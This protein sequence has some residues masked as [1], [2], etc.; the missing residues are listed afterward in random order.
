MTE[1]DLTQEE[2]EAAEK[3]VRHEVGNAYDVI[4]LTKDYE[5]IAGIVFVLVHKQALLTR[6]EKEIEDMVSRIQ[7]LRTKEEK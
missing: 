6:R 7:M 5:N 1:Q 4:R 3:I 2:L